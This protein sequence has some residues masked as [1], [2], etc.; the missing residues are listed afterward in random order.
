MNKKIKNYKAAA[1]GWGALASTTRFVLGSKKPAANLRNLLRANKVKGFD[2]P[3]CA[4]GDEQ[5]KH[6][7]FCENGAKAIS[8]EATAKRVTPDFFRQH[9]VS[10][11]RQQSDY[12][13]EYQGRIEQPMYLNRETD[14]YEPISW[15]DAFALIARHLNGLEH[16]D[17]LELYTSGRASNEA[18]YL[19]QLFGRTV[20][21]NNFPDCSNLCHEASGVAL[22]RAIGVGKGT[23]TL[24]DFDRADAIFAFGQNPGTNHPRMLHSLRNASRRG[25]AIV[26]FNNLKERGLERFA[27]P[28]SPVEMLTPKD[29]SISSLYL[30]PRLGGDMAAVRGMAKLVLEWDTEALKRGEPGLLDRD[31]I[32]EHTQGLDGYMAA[33][34]ATSWQQIEKQSGLSRE[35]IRQAAEVYASAERVIC[36]WAMGITQHKHSV[37][38]IREIVNLQLLR[39]QIG[40][41]GAGLCPVRGHSNVQGNR[42]VGIN[43]K[44][45]E[46][47]LNR[48]ETHFGLPMPRRSGHNAVAAIQA[49]LEG[50]S[51]VFIA[52]GGNIAAAAPDTPVTAEALARCELTVQISTKLNRSH[53]MAG[54]E[55][56]ILPC[57]GRTEADVRASGPQFITVE[58]SF[59]MVHAS[60]GAGKPN[61]PHQRSETAII[62]GMAQATL[63]SKPV[64][65]LALADNYDAIRDHMA[66]TLP[67]FERF[68]ERLQQ[69]G[70]FYLGNTAA[71]HDWQ[72]TTGKAN[73][74]AE[75][76]PAQLL[77]AEQNGEPVSTLQ[78]LRSHDQYNTTIYG[79]D[80]RYRGVYGQRMVLFM[81]PDEIDRRGL[82]EG[83]EVELISIWQ[84]DVERKVSGFRVVAY[85][86]PAGNVAAYYPETNPLVPLHS[87][88]DDSHTPTSKSVAVLIRRQQTSRIL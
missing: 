47:F 8:W 60:Q 73:F 19:Y 20:G 15:D 45:D 37:A 84:D 16:P 56:L 28:Q 40:K 67:G 5:G 80:D 64:D 46:A 48:L 78:T 29:S 79:M 32:A 66:A 13:L 9:P 87:T 69:P 41:P 62:A 81:H 31:F 26:T 77:P 83:D 88:G 68:N 51:K 70:G 61:S 14:H 52:L 21:T 27:D 38:T 34:A 3:G 86:I 2:C 35:Q 82:N 7:S 36:T 55:A 17:Q 33:V 12:F 54:R 63:G 30:C 24:Q 25:A 76:L 6:F 75:P 74:A 50:R 53:L 23:V 42:T 1:G 39:G 44:P 49:M 22:N 18:T 43:E 58:D 85:D 72:T 71:D 10:R 59:S 57:L 4:W 11:L 65:W